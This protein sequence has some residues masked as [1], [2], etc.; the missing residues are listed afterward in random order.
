MESVSWLY[1]QLSELVLCSGH[2]IQVIIDSLQVFKHVDRVFIQV[3]RFALKSG[4]DVLASFSII[5]TSHIGM[6]KLGGVIVIMISLKFL[7]H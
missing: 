7:D 5:M 2:L 3:H 6:T 4:Y 1:I